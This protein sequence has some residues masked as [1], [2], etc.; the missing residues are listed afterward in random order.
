MYRHRREPL[1]APIVAAPAPVTVNPYS[2]VDT[3]YLPFTSIVELTPYSSSNVTI[4]TINSINGVGYARLSNGFINLGSV[5]LGFKW[6]IEGWFNLVS[7]TA[8]LWSI[9]SEFA[10]S[11]RQSSLRF[12]IQ[13]RIYGSTFETIPIPF[14]GL[15]PGWHHIA[16][17]RQHNRLQVYVDLVLVQEI[18]F[19]YSVLPGVFILGQNAIT[20]TRLSASISGFR[21]NSTALYPS[22]TSRGQVLEALKPVQVN[23]VDHDRFE[24]KQIHLNAIDAAGGSALLPNSA[25]TTYDAAQGCW[26]IA[27]SNGVLDWRIDD[28]GLTI[29]PDASSELGPTYTLELAFKIPLNSSDITILSSWDS[30]NNRLYYVQYEATTQQ[31]SLNYTTTGALVTRLVLGLATRTDWDTVAIQGLET[32]TELYLNGKKISTLP[33]L[34]RQPISLRYRFNVNADAG[35]TIGTTLYLKTF[36]V[37]NCARFAQDY[38]PYTLSDKVVEPPLSSAIVRYHV[39]DSRSALPVETVDFDLVGSAQLTPGTTAIYTVQQ[40]GA[41]RSA[42]P[43]RVSIEFPSQDEL[44]STDLQV[45]PFTIVALGDVSTQIN[46]LL[47]LF[48][49]NPFKRSFTLVVSNRWYRRSIQVSVVDARPYTTTTVTAIQGYLDGYL[50]R[51]GGIGSLP[52]ITNTKTASTIAAKVETDLYGTA[53]RFQSPLDK[54]ALSSSLSGVR[55]IVLLYRELALTPNRQYVG[56]STEYTFNGGPQGELVGDLITQSSSYIPG[57]SVP[58]RFSTC[59]LSGSNSTIVLVDDFSNEV[60]IYSRNPSGVWDNDPTILPIDP[61]DAAALQGAALALNQAGTC[62]AI[63]FKNGYNGEGMVQV[64]KKTGAGWMKD[65][66]MGSPVPSPYLGGFGYQ[67]ALSESGTTLAVSEVGSSKVYLFE[68]TALWDA[69][70]LHTFVGAGRFGFSLSLNALGTVLAISAVDLNT[71]Y[72][73]TKTPVWGSIEEQIPFSGSVSL[74]PFENTCLISNLTTHSAKL[75]RKQTTWDVVADF[76]NSLPLY[77]SASAL[78]NDSNVYIASPNEQKIYKYPV[79]SNWIVPEVLPGGGTSAGYAISANTV[80][81]LHSNYTDTATLITYDQTAVPSQMARVRQNGQTV[82][83]GA[84]LTVEDVSLLVFQTT[85]PLDIDQIGAGNTTNGLNGLFLGAM[86]YDKLLSTTQ[87]SSIELFLRKYLMLHRYGSY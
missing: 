51:T 8:S 54:I 31:L 83:I 16:V 42:V 6:T 61:V 48:T 24:Y 35:T 73:Y 76:N 78:D 32:T 70:P 67:V 17:C 36:S 44:S 14:A 4:E 37:L 21:I 64:W 87:L 71:T 50:S 9:G 53:Y 40:K 34:L 81:V 84:A 12:E 82:A 45:D 57:L 11:Y 7:T 20:G 5:S 72:I 62:L 43:Y 77:A 2:E 58:G 28:R 18:E 74:H 55:T 41:H 75:F 15:S 25:S 69:S 56:H 52:N 79:S 3:L 26:V 13:R 22:A 23:Q 1:P 33:F 63:G 60:L 68:K 19:N 38:I 66:Q 49:V 30:P 47:K 85:I 65:L 10:V 86:F 46:L 29:V 80:S 59:K 39:P 27:P